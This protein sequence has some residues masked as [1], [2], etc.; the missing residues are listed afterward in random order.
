MLFCTCSKF[1]VMDV[2]SL[3][4]YRGGG[5]GEDDVGRGRGGSRDL[6]EDIQRR[7]LLDLGLTIRRGRRHEFVACRLNC[8]GERD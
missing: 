6:F 7:H 4:E 3:N 8:R 1:S 2:R 5:G